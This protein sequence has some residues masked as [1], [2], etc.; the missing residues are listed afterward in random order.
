MSLKDE[1]EAQVREKEAQKAASK[2]AL[3]RQAADYLIDVPA[4][5]LTKAV[6][7][8]MTADGT[9]MVR[10]TGM[11][12]FVMIPETV[13]GLQKLKLGLNLSIPKIPFHMICQILN[14]FI[15]VHEKDKTEASALIF[16][17]Q[18]TKEH[19]IYI[20][21]QKNSGGLSEFHED[22]EVNR[23]RLDK[24]PVMEI[25]SHHT[26]G[27]FWS[28]TDN[29]N[30]NAA[31]CYMVF[32]T[33]T[34]S[35]TY[36]TRYACAGQQVNIPIWEIVEK[37][38]IAMNVANQKYLLQVPEVMGIFP[39]VS[40][41]EEW[42]TK[43]KKPTVVGWQG[44]RDYLTYG[45]NGKVTTFGAGATTEAIPQKKWYFH[46]A[47]TDAETN[48][49]K[50]TDG[51]DVHRLQ[52]N[53][54]SGP[55]HRADVPNQSRVKNII[56]FVVKNFDDI[57]LSQLI[58]TAMFSGRDVVSPVEKGI[59]YINENPNMFKPQQDLENCYTCE[60][61]S[62]CEVC[63]GK[64]CECDRIKECQ[65]ILDFAAK[66]NLEAAKTVESCDGPDCP[67]Y[68]FCMS[69]TLQYRCCDCTIEDCKNVHLK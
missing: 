16:W 30:E 25:H 63:S 47:G 57:S 39:K 9:K 3:I 46:G 6:N 62:L 67:H 19:F 22:P 61:A 15:A 40:F 37:P 26:M 53:V 65:P 24:V 29:A 48:S 2:A 13:P 11:G 28:G 1:L 17:D 31:Q 56:D 45:N 5:G 18:D 7:Y 35:P 38:E 49:E 33:I 66:K 59:K 4:E 54:L 43:L 20:P 42:M 32:G 10:H 68:T 58:L 27:A 52:T 12:D 36:L 34:T 44:G 51:A 41:P 64:C 21:E 69:C 8:I 14:F 23:L 60:L 55:E 50:K